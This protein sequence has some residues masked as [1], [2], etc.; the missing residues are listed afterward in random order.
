MITLVS[1]SR[2]HDY[3]NCCVRLLVYI[4]KILAELSARILIST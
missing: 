3:L 4:Y 1:R 2:G